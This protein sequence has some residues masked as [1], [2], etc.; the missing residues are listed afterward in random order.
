MKE[1]KRMSRYYRMS[2]EIEEFDPK[3][4]RAIEN[5]AEDEWGFEDW[6]EF[7]GSRCSTSEGNL[8]AGETEEEFADR[9][10]AVIWHANGDKPCKVQ[11]IATYLED[12]PTEVHCR[13]EEDWP[14]LK[15]LIPEE[16]EEV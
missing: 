7:K 11:V 5:A 2:L 10:T 12:L 9:L 6:E 13:S 4:I 16:E 15:H 3:R 8:C 14:R 1:V